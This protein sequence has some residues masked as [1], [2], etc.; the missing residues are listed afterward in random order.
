LWKLE[1]AIKWSK[2]KIEMGQK[3]STVKRGGCGCCGKFLNVTSSFKK[4]TARSL[5][6]MVGSDEALEGHVTASDL[7]Q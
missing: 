7:L 3:A 2:Q 6:R 1:Y 5:A 4:Q